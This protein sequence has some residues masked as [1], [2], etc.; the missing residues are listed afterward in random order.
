[1]KAT[2]DRAGTCPFPNVAFWSGALVL[3]FVT[4][5]FGTLG[6]PNSAPCQERVQYGA[7]KGNFLR[8]KF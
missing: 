3:H 6:N 4:P 1:M 5:H 2:Q 7:K 8:Q